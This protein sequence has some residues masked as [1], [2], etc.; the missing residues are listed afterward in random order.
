MLVNVAIVDDEKELLESTYHLVVEAFN[1][2]K[3]ECSIKLYDRGKDLIYDMEENRYF[4]IYILDIVM[5]DINGMKL[6]KIIK[7]NRSESYIIF[8][9]S[10]VEFAVD[11]YELNV[12]RFIP[13]TLMRR[14]LP[15]VMEELCFKMKEL[16]DDY[17][18]IQ[19]NSRYEKIY[20]KNIMYFYKNRKNTIFVTIHGE[21]KVRK[22]IKLVMEEIGS[23]DF[24]AIDRGV[25]VNI[26]RI[27]KIE[28]NKVILEDNSVLFISRSH[29]RS[30]KLRINCFWGI[31][32]DESRLSAN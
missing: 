4:D 21:S 31:A 29:L 11:G 7:Q 5:P 26:S 15:K 32:E 1:M 17:Y 27:M 6:A 16:Q 30:V 19:T 9:T 20:L 18:I 12:S 13:K 24:V 2:L 28:S 22:T 14:K 8:L 3:V 23:N 25:V 10:H